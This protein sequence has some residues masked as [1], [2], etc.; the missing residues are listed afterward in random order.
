MRFGSLVGVMSYSAEREK[1]YWSGEL[2]P[3]TWQWAVEYGSVIAGCVFI[4]VVL[5]GVVGYGYAVLTMCG[6]V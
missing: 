4:L 5:C 2:E 1:E 3:Y 6:V